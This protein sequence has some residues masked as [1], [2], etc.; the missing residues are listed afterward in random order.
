[1]HQLISDGI[2]VLMQ[3]PQSD[4]EYAAMHSKI[5]VVDAKVVIIGSSNVT[6]HSLSK[7]CEMVAV[8][9]SAAVGHFVRNYL[10]DQF[11]DLDDQ[12]VTQV[13]SDSAVQDA[14]RNRRY[15]RRAQSDP[16]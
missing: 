12:L 16:Y 15:P 10:L 1:M 2:P 7:N 8:I 6:T 11:H 5:W 13:M 4:S 14:S 9:E 3:S